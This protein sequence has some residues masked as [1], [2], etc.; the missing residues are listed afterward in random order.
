MLHRNIKITFRLNKD[1]HQ[2]FSNQVKNTGYSQEGFIRALIRGYQPK[3]LPPLDY[4]AMIQ[5]LHAISSNLNQI[6]ARANA[7]GDIDKA[8]YLSD[9][10]WLRWAVLEIQEA[11]TVPKRRTEEG[12]E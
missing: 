7:I 11:F 5:E 3:E 6:A 1:E 10:N 2:S 12:G 8:A 9:V 4:H